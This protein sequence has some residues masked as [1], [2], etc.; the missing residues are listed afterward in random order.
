MATRL[1]DLRTF[2]TADYPHRARKSIDAQRQALF[3]LPPE[4]TREATWRNT[5]AGNLG[6]RVRIALRWQ[7][8][9]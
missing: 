1:K 9:R 6:G 5:V 8:I 7:Y 4:T 3:D 2:L